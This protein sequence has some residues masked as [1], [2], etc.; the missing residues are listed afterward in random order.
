MACSLF[1]KFAL[2]SL[3]VLGD[4]VESIAGA[5]L[6]DTQL[7]LNKVWKIFEPLLSP[8]VTPDN[9][10]LPPLRELS[11]LCS[12]HGYFLNA[13][14]ENK[15]DM[16]VATL[17]VQLKDVLFVRRGCERNKKAAKGQAAVLLLKDLEV[18]QSTCYHFL[19]AS[20]SFFTW[21]P[22]SWFI[23]LLLCLMQFKLNHE[24]L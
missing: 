6:I 9:L 20:A 14:C 15:G 23:F 11:E 10:E 4:I 17:E 12:H 22:L 13:K 24:D 21:L 1:G 3:Q 18:C 2:F 7:D 8:I 19:L 16:V 5:I